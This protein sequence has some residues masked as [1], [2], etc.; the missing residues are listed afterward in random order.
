MPKKGLCH[1]PPATV[2][3]L[4]ATSKASV[5]T[6]QEE[7]KNPPQMSHSLLRLI[8]LKITGLHRGW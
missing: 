6:G 3:A 1:H 2:C 5:L 4:E 8:I 7:R